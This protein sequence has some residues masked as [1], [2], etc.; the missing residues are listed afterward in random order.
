VRLGVE[1]D[2]VRRQVALQ[3]AHP[4]LGVAPLVDREVAFEGLHRRDAPAGLVGDELGPLAGRIERS[5]HDPEVD[6]VEVRHHHEPVTPVIEVVL[7]VVASLHHEL[8]LGERVAG[9]QQPL[10]R[11]LLAA[12][13]DHDVLV[14]PRRAD[15]H[16]EALVGLG[17]DADVVGLRRTE[18]VAPHLERALLL[19]G[20]H[21]EEVLAVARPRRA[22]PRGVTQLVVE[23]RA[24][25]DI[26]DPHRV[27]LVAL[28]VARPC[29]E[30]VVEARLEEA[31][32]E[33]VVARR[34]HVL[35][36]HDHVA[37]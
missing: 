4:R 36:E 19:V 15:A 13:V 35:V 20:G 25:V 30:P 21:V 8:G 29:G 14:A 5:G 22:G 11:G 10:L 17:V 9:A 23:V 34:L 7:D 18:S 31:E 1:L 32:V 6:G 27:A 33:E 26:A 28:G 12:A 24:G 16:E 2:D 37:G 3:H